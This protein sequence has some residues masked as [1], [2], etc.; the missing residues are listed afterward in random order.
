L[1]LSG[2]VQTEHVAEW[3]MVQTNAIIGTLKL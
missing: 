3:E 2:N 1:L